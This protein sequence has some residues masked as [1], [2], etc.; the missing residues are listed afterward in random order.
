[1]VGILA[2]TTS[3]FPSNEGVEDDGIG[4]HAAS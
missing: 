3:L 2:S 4:T 1:M